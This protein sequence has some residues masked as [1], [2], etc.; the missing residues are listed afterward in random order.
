[1][2]SWTCYGNLRRLINIVNRDD[3]DDD[4]DDDVFS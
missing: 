1:M 2:T 3:D 4:D